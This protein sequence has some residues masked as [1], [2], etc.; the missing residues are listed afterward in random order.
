MMTT[1]VIPDSSNDNFVCDSVILSEAAFEGSTA[2]LSLLALKKNTN[3][4]H[5]LRENGHFEYIVHSTSY[6][7]TS[8]ICVQYKNVHI[9][10]DL[11]DTIFTLV[12]LVSR[13]AP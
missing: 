11:T 12:T 5:L 13:H 4:L 7:C 6:M 9:Y 8:Y 1:V 2:F 3:A 10:P